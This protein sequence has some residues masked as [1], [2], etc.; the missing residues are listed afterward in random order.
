M[1][2]K[3]TVKVREIII[4]Y[5]QKEALQKRNVALALELESI[6]IHIQIRK[7]RNLIRYYL[8]QAA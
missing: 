1:S 8:K 3:H 4:W 5:R 7:A 2:N 6:L